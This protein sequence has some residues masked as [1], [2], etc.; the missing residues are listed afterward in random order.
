MY[1]DLSNDKSGRICLNAKQADI[2]LQADTLS[3]GRIGSSTVPVF[4]DEDGTPVTCSLDIP[5]DWFEIGVAIAAETSLNNYK[6]PGKYYCNSTSL[7]AQIVDSPVTN[8]NYVLYVFA[9][10]SS[11]TT[12]LQQM[13]IT[14]NSAIYL[15]GCSSNGEWRAWQKMA[16]ESD[17]SGL[18]DDYLPLTAGEEKKL[19]GPLG[20]T[21]DV[22]YG[23]VLPA[24]GFDGQLFF[25]EDDSSFLPTGGAANYVLAKNSTIDGDASWKSPQ[26]TWVA[27]TT[28]GPKPKIFN[29]DGTAIPA[30]SGS[31]SGIITTGSQVIAGTKTFNA[32]SI[33]KNLLLLQNDSITKGTAPSSDDG[34]YIAWT[35][36]QGVAA[37]NRTAMIYGFTNSTANHLRLY[38]YQPTNAS[39]SNTYLYIQYNNDGTTKA[40]STAKFYGAVW[41]DYAE[42][43]TQEETIEP[44][45]CV[46]SA[47]NG[48]VY[49]TT[50]KFQACDGIV[51]DTFGFSI[52]ETD[53]CQ[54]P[55]A[56]AGRV[57][58]YFH[59]ERS[60]YHSGDTVCAG[61][62]GKVMKMTREEI[63]EYP[64][65]IIGIVSEIPEYETWGSGNIA[66]NNRIWIK[67][68]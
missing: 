9:R 13:I 48:K 6:T 33:H 37:A 38:A 11:N 63:R 15:R 51:S 31:A 65:R 7:S 20:L 12:S 28:N 52:G 24:S 27:G 62:E 18:L 40:G 5:I 1:V 2:A 14:M 66:V 57:L 3:C 43:R 67:I 44:G 25:L 4:F 17:L 8:D 45:Y 60:D 34:Q 19:T 30:A 53:E 55:L 26:I 49:K 50:E 35:D 46:A 10:T 47:D 54:T 42:F 59:G 29:I 41:N 56:V 22:M 39:T 58:A 61:P 21:K 16:K 68:K 23:T 64:D 36:S 32:S